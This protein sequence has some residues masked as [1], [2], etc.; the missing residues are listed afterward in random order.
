MIFILS[1][2]RFLSLFLSMRNKMK[3][4][5]SFKWFIH[6]FLLS[7]SLLAGGRKR[8]LTIAIQGTVKFGVP[9]ISSPISGAGKGPFNPSYWAQEIRDM[10]LGVIHKLR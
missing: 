6:K 7:Y 9:V 5:S 8:I 1:E 4:C 2:K 10:A 3:A